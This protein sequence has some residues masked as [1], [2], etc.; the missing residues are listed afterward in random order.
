M[1]LDVEKAI[2]SDKDLYK[3]R[4]PH[5]APHLGISIQCKLSD[6]Y[7]FGRFL[8]ILAE[9]VPPTLGKLAQEC[10]KYDSFSY[11]TTNDLHTFISNLFM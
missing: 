11:P 10:M 1:L 5:I 2:T 9:E 3:T 6:I 7:S 4:Y 8:W